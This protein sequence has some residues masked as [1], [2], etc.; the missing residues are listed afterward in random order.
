MQYKMEDYL[1][2]IGRDQNARILLV[3][4]NNNLAKT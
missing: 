1:R 3:T 4:C 2:I